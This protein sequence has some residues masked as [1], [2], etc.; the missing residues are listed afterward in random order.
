MDMVN[1][2]IDPA[3]NVFVLHGVDQSGKAVFI[4]PWGS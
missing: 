1:V 2:G 3:K 4:K